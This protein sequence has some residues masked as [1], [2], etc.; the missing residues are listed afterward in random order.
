M[1]RDWGIDLASHR[2]MVRINAGGHSERQELVI[3]REVLRAQP[4]DVLWKLVLR[5]GLPT[6]IG[7]DGADAGLPQALN[8]SVSV[9][10]TVPNMRPVKQR[11]DAGVNRAQG[12]DEIASIGIFGSIH[13][14]RSA[15]NVSLIVT[16]QAIGEDTA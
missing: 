7:V 6:A 8:G 4:A 3:G 11:G 5:P 13:R 15:G 2:P 16:E 1:D 12:A 10:G 9:L 14:P